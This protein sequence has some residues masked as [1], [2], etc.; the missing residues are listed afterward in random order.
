[1]GL[2]GWTEAGPAG[3]QATYGVDD[4]LITVDVPAVPGDDP[5]PAADDDTGDIGD[6][7]TGCYATCDHK[8]PAQTAAVTPITDAG[9]YYT[10]TDVEAM[11]QEIGASIAALEAGGSVASI[12]SPGTAESIF[13]DS[14]GSHY[15][16][17][18]AM[19]RLDENHVFLASRKA[20]VHEED[21]T[22]TFVG[23][24]IT[25]EPDGSRTYGSA[26]TILASSG[27]DLRG[28]AGVTMLRDGETVF[29]SYATWDGTAGGGRENYCIKA[30]WDKATATLSAFGTP[31]RQASSFTQ[32]E[33]NSGPI[34]EDD[35]GNLYQPFYGQDTGWTRRV[36][37]LLKDDGNQGDSW[38]G[39][40]IDIADVAGEY[41]TE[42]L[43]A[44][45]DDGRWASLIRHAADAS[46]TP[47]S[48]DISFSFD[49]LHWTV[50]S[51][52]F[53]GASLAAFAQGTSGTLVSTFR[54]D[55][56]GTTGRAVMRASY[57]RG[58][59]WTD[60]VNLE[61]SGNQ[62][63]YA[64]VLPVA[65]SFWIAYSVESSSTDAD[66]LL[67]TAPDID[68]VRY[69]LGIPGSTTS[70]TAAETFRWVPMSFDPSGDGNYELMFTD[71]G[72]VMMME[73]YD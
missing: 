44:R 53:E 7:T 2:K 71:D 19:C 4:G 30:T 38:N 51:V 40:E 56:G 69:S 27:V 6:P 42:P 11:G 21:T 1:M 55:N 48:I 33:Y 14:S 57:N 12:G 47:E 13:N 39:G 43:V 63:N 68:D 29:L 46:G 62:M 5:P 16:A 52:A 18:P 54:H 49:L 36:C 31:I 45:M 66:V 65:E 70:G 60:E 73:V 34:I 64:S 72:S 10:G 26:F 23:K 22:S 35:D 17:F 8:H 15:Y 50:P 37:R 3:V 41:M 9:G 24:I 67:V 28:V 20:T 25:I 61:T 59:D 58:V 32:L